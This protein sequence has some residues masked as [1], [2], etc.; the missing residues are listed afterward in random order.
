MTKLIKTLEYNS[1]FDFVD[2]MNEFDYEYVKF[3]GGRA[4]GTYMLGIDDEDELLYME[5]PADDYD[6]K[7]R[8]VAAL[9]L[10]QSIILPGRFNYLCDDTT[11]SG[12]SIEFKR[13]L[14]ECNIVNQFL[15]DEFTIEGTQLD[16]EGFFSKSNFTGFTDGLTIKDSSIKVTHMF[17]DSNGLAEVTFKNCELSSL[18]GLTSNSDVECVTFEGCSLVVKDNSHLKLHER[19]LEA[20][21]LDEIFGR[22]TITVNLICC[23][24]SLIEELIKLN[25]REQQFFR[26]LEINILD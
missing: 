4:N 13:T 14:A 21:C 12:K 16:M 25:S 1:G 22:K 3:M 26:E 5:L 24:D 6:G 23:D 17:G 8:R 11:Q 10:K 2:M 18:I 15:D 7:V 19:P 9:G 20:R